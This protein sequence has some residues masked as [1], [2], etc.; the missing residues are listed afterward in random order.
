MYS[1][2]YTPKAVNAISQEAVPD[3]RLDSP[4]PVMGGHR[5]DPWLR[6]NLEI[7]DFAGSGLN[8]NQFLNIAEPVVF[9]YLEL[10]HY[11]IQLL[12]STTSTIFNL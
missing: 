5:V 1:P 10:S 4:C 7:M 2:L 9:R 3:T 8:S 6:P 12:N 11:H